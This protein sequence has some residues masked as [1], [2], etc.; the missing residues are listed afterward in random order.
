MMSKGVM[1][2]DEFDEAAKEL[3]DRLK[4]RLGREH[5]KFADEFWTHGEWDLLMESVLDALVGANTPISGEEYELVRR[6][7]MH[8]QPPGKDIEFINNREQV[9]ESL[10]VVGES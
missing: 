4:G 8:F 9:L 10:N 5:E 7:V 2:F 6:L 3:L 1:T